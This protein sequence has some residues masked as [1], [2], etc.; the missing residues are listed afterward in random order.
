VLRRWQRLLSPRHHHQLRLLLLLLLRSH[1]VRIVCLRQKPL[2]MGVGKGWARVWVQLLG[3][4]MPACRLGSLLLQ[5][6][7]PLLAPTL[8]PLPQSI[9]T[10]R[11]RVQRTAWRSPSCAQPLPC[12]T[13][14]GGCRTTHRTTARASRQHEWRVSNR[15]CQYRF[16]FG[17]ALCTNLKLCTRLMGSRDNRFEDAKHEGRNGSKGKRTPPVRGADRANG[18]HLPV[19]F[20]DQHAWVAGGGTNGAKENVEMR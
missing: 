17:G 3:M 4:A 8:R 18:K 1:N 20:A 2:V 12:S 15:R 14:V 5:P 13:K 10:V 16:Y 7:A 9:P 11:L 19:A 6:P